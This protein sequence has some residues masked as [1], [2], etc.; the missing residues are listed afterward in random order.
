MVETILSAY[1]IQEQDGLFR[2]PNQLVTD[3]NYSVRIPVSQENSTLKAQCKEA[4][5]L[6]VD[7]AWWLSA[8]MSCNSPL[9]IALARLGIARVIARHAWALEL[10]TLQACTAC[11]WR[12]HFGTLGNQLNDAW[13]LAIIAPNLCSVFQQQTSAC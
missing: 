4:L 12:A 10:L 3:F 5:S 1:S 7:C 11:P 2:V 8:A 6:R 13:V 9:C